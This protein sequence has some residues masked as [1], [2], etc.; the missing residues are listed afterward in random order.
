MTTL[1][2]RCN[3]ELMTCC[4]ET[5]K[6]IKHVGLVCRLD[7]SNKDSTGDHDSNGEGKDEMRN[8]EFY[9]RKLE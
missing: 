2:I 1:V 6:S 7:V 5:L 9:D 3:F 8:I 4:P